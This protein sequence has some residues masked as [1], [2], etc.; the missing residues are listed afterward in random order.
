MAQ[1]TAV[2]TF[3]DSATAEGSSIH[4]RYLE[5][6]LKSDTLYIC[7]TIPEPVKTYNILRAEVGD[8]QGLRDYANA[9]ALTRSSPKFLNGFFGTIFMD[10]GV[11]TDLLNA[12]GIYTGIKQDDIEEQTRLISGFLDS[13]FPRVHACVVDFKKNELSTCFVVDKMFGTQFQF[14]GYLEWNCSELG[15]HI[16]RKALRAMKNAVTFNQFLASRSC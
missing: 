13:T 10:T 16:H 9:M 3:H 14:G 12:Q 4:H 1:A 6:S 8:L 11:L 2:V 5:M 7:D 15:A